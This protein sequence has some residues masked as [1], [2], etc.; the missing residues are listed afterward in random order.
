MDNNEISCCEPNKNDDIT[1]V[2]FWDDQYKQ[3]NTGWDLKQVSPPIKA[4]FDQLVDHKISIL[5]AGCGNAYE[6]EYLYSLGFEDITLVDISETLVKSLREKFSHLPIKILHEDIFQ[7]GGK[8]DLI[9]EQTLFCAIDPSLRE[10][11][12]KKMHDLLVDNG[13]L[14]GLLFATEFE[15][16]GPPFGGN[17][18]EYEKLFAEY[19]EFKTFELCYNSIGPR[20]GNELFFIFSKIK[21]NK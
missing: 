19:F 18:E 5:I 9:V 20:L 21:F 14:V 2:K 1:K 15:K 10:D 13:K 4:Y 8:Y 3:G 7:H 12:A 17:K 6:A 11:Y 16:A